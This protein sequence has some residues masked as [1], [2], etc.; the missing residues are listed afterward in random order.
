MAEKCEVCSE[1]IEETFL[2]KLKG[3][4]VKVKAGKKNELHYLCSECQKQGKDKE[5]KEGRKIEK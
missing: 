3:T 5:L 2:G 4:V 1:K